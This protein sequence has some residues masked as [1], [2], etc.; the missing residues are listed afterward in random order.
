MNQNATTIGTWAHAITRALDSYGIDGMAMCADAGIDA[1]RITDPNYRIPVTVMTPFWRAAVVACEDSAFGLRVAEHVSPTTFHALGYAAIASRDFQEVTKRLTSNTAVVSEVAQT[2][3]LMK[4]NLIWL[5]IEILEDSPEVAHEAIDAFMGC[6]VQMA[7][8]FV[9]IDIP[10]IE[11]HMH[12]PKPEN[13]LAFEEFFGA[14]VHFAS[15]TNALVCPLSAAM[16]LNPSYNPALVAANDTVLNEY[17]AT[18]ARSLV[19]QVEQQIAAMLPQEPL[20]S[21]VADKL[22]M[23]VRK[24]QRALEKEGTSYQVI[25]DDYRQSRAI[26]M[27]KQ[28]RVG[29]KEVAYQLGFANQSAFTRAFKRWTG[30]TPKE[31]SDSH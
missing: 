30:K 4:D 16:M 31:F 27:I 1:Q 18:Q 19:A 13:G 5:C 20:Q 23:S 3:V 28:G 21:S 7:K 10:L 11:V 8:K 15:D 2:K 12:R 17:K 14:P 6:I 9:G 22:N 25:L 24:M 29:F 26:S